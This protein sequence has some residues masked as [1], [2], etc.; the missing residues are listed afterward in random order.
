M[1]WF[2]QHPAYVK[3]AENGTGARSM[4]KTLKAILSCLKSELEAIYADR[5]V[6]L[7]LFGSQARGDAQPGSDIDALVVLSGSVNPSMEIAR[8]GPTTAGLSLENDV[9]ISCVFMS[10]ERFAT[11]QSPLLINVRREGVAA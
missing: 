7:V 4:E 2:K 8:V 3:F 11:E 10:E 6:T 9:V 5:M 1:I